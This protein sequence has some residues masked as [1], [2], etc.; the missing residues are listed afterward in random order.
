LPIPQVRRTPLC[1]RLWFHIVQGLANRR[2]KNSVSIA[3]CVINFFIPIFHLSLV[4]AG[5]NAPHLCKL[6]IGQGAR[7]PAKRLHFFIF[8]L[9]NAEQ[10]PTIAQL[11]IAER[12]SLR[13]LDRLIYDYKLRNE[14]KFNPSA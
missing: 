11:P 6:R 10:R 2:L 8:V 5:T 12:L 3:N 4:K 1:L 9:P 7:V 13:S 14:K